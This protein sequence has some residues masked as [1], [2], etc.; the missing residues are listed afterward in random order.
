VTTT[1]TLTPR[2]RW[3][4]LRWRRFAETC[5]T[6]PLVAYLF[7]DPCFGRADSC[8]YTWVSLRCTSDSPR[9]NTHLSV[10][11]SDFINIH[12]WTTTISLARVL[13]SR[14][15]SGAK[16]VILDPIFIVISIL[17]IFVCH[18]RKIHMLKRCC[19][20]SLICQGT[21]SDSC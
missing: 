10:D 8:V 11:T 9:D 2:M 3:S 4:R 12:D 16:H 19:D 1:P 5:I 15:I 7:L 14:S 13:S 17:A 18:V 20:A 21:Q 6:F